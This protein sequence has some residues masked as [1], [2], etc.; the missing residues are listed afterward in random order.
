MNDRIAARK[1]A[2]FTG[3]GSEGYEA[4]NAG[5]RFY[6]CEIKDEYV[7]A[8]QKNIERAMR[9][10]KHDNRSLFDLLECI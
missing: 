5:R 1:E 7:A 2:G 9:L 3:I 4:I 8:A 6:G 10:Q